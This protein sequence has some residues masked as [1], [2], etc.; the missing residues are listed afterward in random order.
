[1]LAYW[2][3]VKNFNLVKS[4]IDVNYRYTLKEEKFM[5]RI[6]YHWYLFM[7]H[8]ESRRLICN[9]RSLDKF[10]CTPS[11]D[12]LTSFDPFAWWFPKQVQRWPWASTCSLLILMSCG[13]RSSQIAGHSQKWCTLHVT[14]NCKFGTVVALESIE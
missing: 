10:V 8:F 1:M 12:G 9:C 14:T 4:I 3:F 13:Q 2:Y 6:V 7:L 11:F 5:F